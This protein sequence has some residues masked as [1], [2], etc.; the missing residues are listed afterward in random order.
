LKKKKEQ[1]QDNELKRI[2]AEEEKQRNKEELEWLE[3]EKDEQEK[4]IKEKQEKYATAMKPT[5]VIDLTKHQEK[6]VDTVVHIIKE[7]VNK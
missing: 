5:E 1:E 4:S 6:G 2:Y 3:R 7:N